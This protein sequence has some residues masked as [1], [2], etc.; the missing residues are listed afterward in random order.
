MALGRRTLLLLLV[1]LAV[2]ATAVE[3][4]VH[5]R[6]ADA[7]GWMRPEPKSC[8]GTVEECLREYGGGFGLR[9]RLNYEEEEGGDGGYSTQT[10]YISYAALMRNSVPC[11]VPGASYYN[12]EP[13]ADSNPYSRGC[14]AITQCRG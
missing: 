8:G 7:A 5:G 2:S 11:S 6:T 13:G 12:C 14:S 4:V 1:T 3:L 10:Q 9:R